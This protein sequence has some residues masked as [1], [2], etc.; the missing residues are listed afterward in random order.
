MEYTLEAKPFENKNGKYKMI[1]ITDITLHT[2]PKKE[3]QSIG[4]KIRK[5]FTLNQPGRLYS[6]ITSASEELPEGKTLILNLLYRDPEFLK[7]VQEEKSKGY[8]ILLGFPKEGI[9][10]MIGKDSQEFLNGVKGKRIIRRL[11]KNKI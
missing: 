11:M 2:S 5:S 6:P 3:D 9:P 1:Q 7:F 10:A 8:K 4:K